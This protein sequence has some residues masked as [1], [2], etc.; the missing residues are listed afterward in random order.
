MGELFEQSGFGSQMN[1]NGRKTSQVYQGQSVY[2]AKDSV[3]KH[4]MKGDQFYLDGSHKNHLEVFDKN[5]NVKAVLNLDGSYNELKTDK[6]IA[7]GRTL[8]K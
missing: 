8:P 6:A 4:I 3:G 5:R 2:E 1:D 7:D